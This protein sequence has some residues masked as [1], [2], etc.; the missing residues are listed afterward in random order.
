[1]SPYASAL[2]TSRIKHS[3]FHLFWAMV[4]TCLFPGRQQ[5]CAAHDS[6]QTA[7][8]SAA[9]QI[10]QPAPAMLRLLQG[11]LPAALPSPACAK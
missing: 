4:G 2:F 11:C 3:Q 7:Q 8:H 6:S 9:H 10:G 1:M 5:L